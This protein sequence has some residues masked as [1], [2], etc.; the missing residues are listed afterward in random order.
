MRPTVPEGHSTVPTGC[1]CFS[2]FG[3]EHTMQKVKAWLPK[4]LSMIFLSAYWV[5]LGLFFSYS[6]SSLMEPWMKIAAIAAGLVIEALLRC[7]KAI[8]KEDEEGL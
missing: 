5:T 2:R 7:R 1:L 3:M 8:F 4:N 6:G